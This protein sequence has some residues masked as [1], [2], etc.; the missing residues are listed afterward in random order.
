MNRL[1]EY[2]PL[3]VILGFIVVS[4]KKGIG[5]KKQEELSKT[6]LPG[7]RSGEEIAIPEVLSV[8]KT[9]VKMKKIKAV[10]VEAPDPEEEGLGTYDTLVINPEEIEELQKA[11][12]YTEI[13]NR[14]EYF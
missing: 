8:K 3:L 10:P 5:N 14:K 6:T 7:R 2:I 9:K 11:V 4:I 13:L 12:I 1:S